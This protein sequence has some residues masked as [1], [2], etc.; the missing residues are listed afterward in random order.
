MDKTFPILNHW[1][2]YKETRHY[3]PSFMAVPWELIAEHQQQCLHNHSQSPER[4][5]SRG[6]LYPSEMLAIIHDEPYYKNRYVTMSL[7]EAFIELA[8]IVKVQ[9][10]E[11]EK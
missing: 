1:R 10:E 4:L 3:K 8:Q 2:Y 5:A 7:D 6:G 9:A 11:A